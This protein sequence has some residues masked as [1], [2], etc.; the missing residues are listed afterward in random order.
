MSYHMLRL[1]IKKKIRKAIPF[2]KNIA[3]LLKPL[4]LAPHLLL[5]FYETT[6]I[7]HIYPKYL[8]TFYYEYHPVEL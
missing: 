8:K 3:M 2:S 5:P 7:L 6:S 1:T 4:I